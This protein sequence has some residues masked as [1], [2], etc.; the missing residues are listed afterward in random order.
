M[1][2]LRGWGQSLAIVSLS[3]P[4]TSGIQA[5]NRF[6]EIWSHSGQQAQVLDKASWPGWP[7][8]RD[9]KGCSYS[10]RLREV[11]QKIQKIISA[12]LVLFAFYQFGFV[13]HRLSYA[14][15]IVLTPKAANTIDKMQD[16]ERLV[17]QWFIRLNELDDWSISMDG[18]EES[19]AVVD[20]FVQ[21]YS[22]NAFHQVSPSDDQVGPVVFSGPA[23]IRKWATD[24]AK[25]YVQLA[26]RI[27]YITRNEKPSQLFYGT[28]PAWGGI[29]AAVEFTGVYT[30]RKERKRFMIPGSAFFLFDD[31][32]K[33]QRVRLYML[34]QELVEIVPFRNF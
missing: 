9:I 20:R 34:Q 4:L 11:V 14:Q 27:D 1:A 17:D 8:R 31:S 19:D 13:Y 7:S 32:G 22:P 26:Y 21:L 29:G 5:L 30:T 12:F 3:R 2:L 10:S 18:K 23:G 16:A 15:E 33:I 28:K 25:S 24:F 6:S